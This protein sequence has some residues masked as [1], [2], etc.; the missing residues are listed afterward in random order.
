MFLINAFLRKKG[1]KQRMF[2]KENKSTTTYGI[3]IDWKQHFC[4]G[5]TCCYFGRGDLDFVRSFRRTGSCGGGDGRRCR[6]KR[7]LRLCTNGSPIPFCN[8]CNQ[9]VYKSFRQSISSLTM[10]VQ[11]FP[12]IRRRNVASSR[13]NF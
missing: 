7:S 10:S 2:Q 12:N 4:C 6:R 3:L 8:V 9:L 13:N 11:S 5:S 1:A